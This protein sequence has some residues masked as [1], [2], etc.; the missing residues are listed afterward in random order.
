M[1]LTIFSIFLTLSFFSCLHTRKM[2]QD[3]KKIL[4]VNQCQKTI[5]SCKEE[6]REP[7]IYQ[8]LY[9][10]RI[11]NNSNNGLLSSRIK[12]K[13]EFAFNADGR[14]R[15]SHSK[16]Q[17]EIWFYG[18]IIDY[19]KIPIRFGQFNRVTAFNLKILFKFKIT[20]NPQKI[21]RKKSKDS[22]TKPGSGFNDKASTF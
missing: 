20:L 6:K 13:L 4:S 17:G 16:N 15:I 1:I 7:K 8:S 3:E 14:L 22:S 11:K 10:D 2:L 18:K 9:V 19:Q 5:R 12:Q 21:D